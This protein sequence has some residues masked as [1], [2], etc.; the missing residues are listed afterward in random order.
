MTANTSATAGIDANIEE[1][2]TRMPSCRARRRSGRSIRSMRSVCNFSND[3]TDS[4]RMEI[5]TAQ[6]LRGSF[7]LGACFQ[8]G[9][10]SIQHSVEAGHILRTQ[11]RLHHLTHYARHVATERQ[12]GG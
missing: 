8:M 1:M 4:E 12:G 9:H 11:H 7:P 5:T 2:M 3:C 6:A 10:V